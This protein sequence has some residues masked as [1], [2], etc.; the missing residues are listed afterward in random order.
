PT[1]R[2]RSSIN[3][4]PVLHD[5]VLIDDWHVVARA[6]DVVEGRPAAVGL[7]DEDV[8]LWR[9]GDRVHAWRDLCVH[10]GARLSLGRAD[11]DRL[12][13]AYHGWTYD[14]D[15]RCVRFPAHPEQ[16]PPPT[17]RVKVYRAVE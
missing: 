9:V 14:E 3:L 8:V 11:G 17:A 7:L 13:C 6:Q 15:G 10:R 16:R 5:P 12:A 1:G 4:D 2:S